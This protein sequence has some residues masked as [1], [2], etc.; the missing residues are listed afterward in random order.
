MPA[1]YTPQNRFR[2]P[3]IRR[4]PGQAQ[5]AVFRDGRN[6]QEWTLVRL[7]GTMQPVDVLALRALIWESIWALQLQV[8]KDY[9]L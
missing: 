4:Q 3:V 2:V 7:R 5:E 6:L 9:A 8:Y 1:A